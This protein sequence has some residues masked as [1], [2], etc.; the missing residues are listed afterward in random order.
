M[1][2]FE[3]NTTKSIVFRPSASAELADISGSLLGANVLFIT[4]PGLR[5]LGLC[6]NAL[7]SLEAAGIAVT[8]FD[9]VE[10][11]PSQATLKA[12]LAAGD[13]AEVTGVVGFGGGSSL[14]IAKV[15]ALLLG[16]REDLDKAWGVGVAK[17]PRMP[18][19][20][21][22]TTSGTGS[23]VT[24]V[25]IITV[26]TE[27]KRGISSPILLPDI[28]IL[29]A[30]LTL[31][32][33][34]AITAATGVDAIVHAIEAYASANC[35]NNPL[36][37][38]LAREALRLLGANIETVVAEPGNVEARGAML[39]GSML[40]GQAFAN[41]PVASVHALAYPI[42]GTFHVP[43]GLSNALVLPHVLRFNAPVAY[44]T[45]AEIAADAFPHL[46]EVE[47]AKDRCAALIDALAG[48]S[49]RLGLQTRL[50][51][52][53]IPKSALEKMAAD[54]MLQ[55]RL[56]VNNPRAM[57]EQDVLKIYEAAW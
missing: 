44:A 32:L 40:A 38:A 12:A 14:D 35:N 36:S 5:K 27:E 2:P 52:V 9:Q 30:E 28:A 54:A 8:V 53:G 49:N 37:K 16:S 45:Y 10:P 21:I 24:P 33:P 6:N 17:G 1:D 41:S 11:D 25:S 7:A 15:A 26:G 23:E 31:D 34:S 29:D 39:L 51:E 48:L 3:F 56:L 13:A 57:S 18:L 20:L 55:T 43:H 22:P 42:G 46:A 47:G 4:D 50:R 19:V